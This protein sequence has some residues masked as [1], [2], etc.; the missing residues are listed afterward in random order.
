[1]PL[2]TFNDMMAD[3][4]AK[5]YYPIYFLMGEEDYFIDEVT[6]YIAKNV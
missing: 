5:K 1:M 2:I 3:L 6:D 4:K